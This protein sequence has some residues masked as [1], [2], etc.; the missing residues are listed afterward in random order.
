VTGHRGRIS[1]PSNKKTGLHVAQ[2]P[3][4]KNIQAKP[5]HRQ[6]LALVLGQHTQVQSK[7]LSSRIPTQEVTSTKL[8][9]W[10]EHIQLS[11]G[12]GVKQEKKSASVAQ[13]CLQK[14]MNGD[15]QKNQCGDWNGTRRQTQNGNRGKSGRADSKSWTEKKVLRAGTRR[16]SKRA[17]ETEFP[18]ARREKIVEPNLAKNRFAESTC[19]RN[20]ARENQIAESSA[21]KFPSNSRHTEHKT[22][23]CSSRSGKIKMGK[24]LIFSLKTNEVTF[25]S[26]RSPLSLLH[27]IIR[28]KIIYSTLTLI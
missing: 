15:E 10:E 11:L 18:A 9:P 16:A 17:R 1:Q 22:K 21:H 4:G 25:N 28:I 20:E 23:L 12:N 24:N 8:L 5:K 14:P 26:R 7:K 27:L 6:D 13:L 2:S 19:E 3:H